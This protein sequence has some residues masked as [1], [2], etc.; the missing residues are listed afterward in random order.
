MGSIYSV[1][2][3][4]GG[5]GK[6]STTH[7]I[8]VQTALAGKRTLAIDED[9]QNSMTKFFGFDFD[10]VG[11]RNIYDV[12]EKNSKVSIR[13]CIYQTHVENLDL[14]P[15]TI[16]L[17]GMEIPLGAR[18]NRERILARALNEIKDEYDFIFIDCP[19]QLSIFTINA[20]SCSNGVI[21]PIE[22]EHA[23]L[24]GWNQLLDTIDEI[25]EE[26][27]SDLEVVGAVATKFDQRINEDKRVLAE[28]KAACIDFPLLEV[29]PR[30][31]AVKQYV[32]D[33]KSISEVE[34]ENDAAIAYKNVAKKIIEHSE[35]A[36]G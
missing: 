29:I 28:I 4:K 14:L 15:A 12:Y 27:N 17:A 20:L 1:A 8:S 11:E 34:P 6:S 21:I 23:A 7:N 32:K 13:D 9:A 36:H 33:G 35:V 10:E 16:D 31:T 22:T 5:V 26:I 25:K 18:T 2:N 19:P 24:N 30:R 3:Q